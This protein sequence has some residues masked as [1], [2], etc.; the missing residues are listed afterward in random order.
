M[1][2]G[3]WINYDESKDFNPKSQKSLKEQKKGTSFP[4]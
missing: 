2:W 3:I 1:E 4:G